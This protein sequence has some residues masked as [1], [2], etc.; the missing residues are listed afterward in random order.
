MNLH[1]QP[2]TD[3]QKR[4]LESEARITI[5]RAGPGSGKTRVFVEAVRALLANWE[6]H[7]A[8]LAA[9][10]FT[11]AAQL[12]IAERLGGHL[13]APHFVGTLDSFVLRHVVRPFASL[14]GIA[15]RGIQLVPAPLDEEMVQPRVQIGKTA[16]EAQPLYRVRFNQGTEN[17]PTFYY[18]SFAGQRKT[19]PP[20]FSGLVMAAKRKLWTASGRVTH[21]DTHYL[22]ACILRSTHGAD[23]AK[24]LAKRFPVLLVDELQDT[25]WFLGRTLIEILRSPTVKSLL[26]GDPDQAIYE[27]G[28]ADP[29][30][31]SQIE[32]LEGAKCF[33]IS[34]SQRCA[35]RICKVATALSDSRSEV[36][37]KSSAREGS[38]TILVHSLPKAEPSAKLV[39]QIEDLTPPSELT[40]ILCRRNQTVRRLQGLETS[41]AFNGGSSP[42]YS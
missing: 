19:V 20:A 32:A 11:N 36:F 23:I 12:E 17:G 15:P 7:R 3:E 4:I 6:D 34:T 38:A 9:L 40:A 1:K 10:S 2:L 21:T 8:G 28:G 42:D 39:T 25:S 22:A 35:A 30:L 13:T 24:L 5:V 27:F 14:I 33:S 18:S 29:T 37:P 26:V 31:F 16:R 41:Q